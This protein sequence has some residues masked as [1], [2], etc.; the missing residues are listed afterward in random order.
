ML[1]SSVLAA[2]GYS[3][4]L[5]FGGGAAHSAIDHFG[6]AVFELLNTM[7]WGIL[8]GIVFVGLLDRVP[9]DVIIAAL[10]G[11]RPLDGHLAGDRRRGGLRSLQ[12]RD[13]DGRH[14]AIREGRHHRPDCRVPAG[15]CV[16][17]VQ[18]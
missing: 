1:I 10:A 5:L 12:S 4:H 11:S 17:L 18:P 9:R 3:W 14:E 13:P 7:W 6:M 16:E 15:Q 8:L 2:L